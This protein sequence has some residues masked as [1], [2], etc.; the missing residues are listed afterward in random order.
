MCPTHPFTLPGMNAFFNFL[1][2]RKTD[3]ISFTPNPSLVPSRDEIEITPLFLLPDSYPPS[4]RFLGRL[5][6][7][8]GVSIALLLSNTTIHVFAE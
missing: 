5:P 7:I 3:T 8:E 1:F 2:L 4:R 6:R